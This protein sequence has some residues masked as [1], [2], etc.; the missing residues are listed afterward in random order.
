MLL[1]DHEDESRRMYGEY[2]RASGL[3]VDETADGRMALAKA[4]TRDPDVIVMETRLPG[5]DGFALCQLLRRDVTTPATPIVL[6]ATDAVPAA[7][8]QQRAAVADIVLPKSYG[9]QA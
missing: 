3:D 2:F 8:E 7:R 9:A 1:E 5:I 4:I 6:V